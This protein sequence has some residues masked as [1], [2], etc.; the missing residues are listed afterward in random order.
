MFPDGLTLPV[1]TRIGFPTKAMQEEAD[2]TFNG[3][4]FTTGS[5]LEKDESGSVSGSATTMSTT[6]L[7]YITANHTQHLDA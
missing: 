1:G 7:A 3:F 5:A 6:N 4:R 2:L